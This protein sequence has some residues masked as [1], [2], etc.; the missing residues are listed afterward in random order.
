MIDFILNFDVHLIEIVKN[1]GALTHFFLFLV[2]FCETGLVFTPFLPGDSLLFIAGALAAKGSLNLALLL[3]LLTT[4]AIV[5]DT[6]NYFAGR[7]FGTK[8]FKAGNRILKEDYLIRTQDFYKK[9]GK[10]A[11]VLARFVPIIRTFAPFVAGIGKMDYKTFLS[12]NI[13]GGTVWVGLFTLG[14]YFFGTLPWVEK[15]FSL[16]ILIIILCS[17]LPVLFEYIKSKKQP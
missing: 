6:V 14:G 15:N 16:V 4:A 17:V 5:G 3:L 13:I 9:Y 1:Y 2:V 10:K 8:V 12:Y 7:Y 11:I